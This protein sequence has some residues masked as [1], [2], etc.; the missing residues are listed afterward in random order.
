[1]RILSPILIALFVFNSFV[2]AQK[3]APAPD[4]AAKHFIV[5][6][7]QIVDDTELQLREVQYVFVRGWV[8]HKLAQWLWRDG[9][10]DSDRAETLAVRALEDI[11]ARRNELSDSQHHYLTADLFNLLD[12]NAKETSDRL[13]KKF[14]F[15]ADVYVLGAFEDLKKPDGD[16][17]AA[18]KLVQLF[19]KP[20]EISLLF[21]PV[22]HALLGKKSPQVPVVLDA[23]LT[24]LES[25]RDT[26]PLN[27]L[28]VTM[29]SFENP[30]V[31][32]ALRARFF[33]LVIAQTRPSLQ[34]PPPENIIAHGLISTAI[35]AFGEDA[36]DLVPEA[37]GLKSAFGLPEMDRKNP[38][39]EAEER[40]AAAE[41]KLA[42]LIEEAERMAESNVFWK[43]MFYERAEKLAKEQGKLEFAMDLI[44]R[45]RAYQKQEFQKPWPDQEYGDIARLAFE[46]DLTETAVRAIGKIG[47]PVKQS[48]SWQ[49]AANYYNQKKD[50]AESRDSIGRALRLLEG[51]DTANIERTLSLIRILT[52]LERMNKVLLPDAT[53]LASKAVNDIPT[54]GADDKPGT[55]KYQG[56][57]TQL[58]S[59]NNAIGATIN[60]LYLKDRG[61][62]VE[63]TERIMRKEARVAADLYIAMNDFDAARK[64]AAKKPADKSTTKN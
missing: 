33:A 9:K 35:K 5:K 28:R 59:V 54:P 50:V 3:A 41:D 42:A 63:F 32:R 10:D 57:I 17:I 26:M 38:R 8:R 61:T 45:T 55:P 34:K 56:Y 39:E 36:P 1:M 16:K 22:L 7:Q 44:E 14:A 52:H 18:A 13:K 20:G 29:V 53:M 25:G 60:A 40:I 58:W 23:L 30:Q 64:E 37:A 46:K 48:T 27:N 49:A 11:Y 43:G 31:P 51:G 4:A 62:A 15:G 19:N 21:S 47:D 12:A 2:F 24:S 6:K